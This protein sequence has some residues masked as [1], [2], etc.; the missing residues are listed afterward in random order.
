[1][2]LKWNSQIR[3]YLKELKYRI[4]YSCFA[5]ATTSFSAFIEKDLIFFEFT[6]PLK[7]L[8]RTISFDSS[9]VFL[10][11]TEAFNVSIKLAIILG[12]LLSLPYFWL[13]V[14]FFLAQTFY[15]KEQQIFRKLLIFSLFALLFAIYI[16][17]YFLLPK[18]WTFFLSF[19]SFEGETKLME[20]FNYLP[21]LNSYLNLAIQVYFT[22]LFTSQW[23]IFLYLLLHWQ[24]L[25]LKNL[26]KSRRW[27][28]L[29]FLIWAAFISPPDLLS[30][31]ILFFPFYTLFEAFLFFLIFKS[32]FLVSQ[33]ENP[34][35][36]K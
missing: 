36:K 3:G 15:R 24:W 34:K 22:L 10:Q 5:L 4:Y 25:H 2:T 9:F 29:F 7:N 33:K 21:G 14:W 20:N 13:Q 16:S 35:P 30:L 31:F 27:L 28:I 18:A 32:H 23:P 11:L 12:L 26:L 17:H 19:G 6:Q 1:M 8:E